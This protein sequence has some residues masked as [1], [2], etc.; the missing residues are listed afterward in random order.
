[1]LP[2]IKKLGA[3]IVY[4]LPLTSIGVDGH[5]GDLGSPY[6]INNPYILDE[7][8]NEPLLNMTME[9]QFKAVIEATHHL[10]MKVVSEFIFR[11]SSKDSKLAIE[12]PD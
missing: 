1:L 2:Y 7:N 5:K 11:T 8:L 6:S 4:F 12:H 3:D 10:G 9:E